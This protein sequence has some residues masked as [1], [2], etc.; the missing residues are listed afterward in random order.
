MEQIADAID[1]CGADQEEL[2]STFASQIA[3]LPIFADE[4]YNSCRV[5]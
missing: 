2:L 1:D 4:G 3:S 5:L